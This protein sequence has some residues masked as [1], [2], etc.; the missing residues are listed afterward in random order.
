MGRDDPGAVTWADPNP[1][2]IPGP[3]SGREILTRLQPTQERMTCGSLSR[4]DFCQTGSSKVLGHSR[5]VLTGLKVGATLRHVVIC[6]SLSEAGAFIFMVGSVLHGLNDRSMRW[7]MF[8]FGKVILLQDFL[9][10]STPLLPS[11][12]SQAR[13]H[14]PTL[15]FSHK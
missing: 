6:L 8:F 3:K 11:A 13:A 14:T 4:K 9:L 1:L 7:M 12:H 15:C 5:P 2:L 10:L